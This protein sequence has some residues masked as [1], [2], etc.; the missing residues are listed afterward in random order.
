MLECVFVCAGFRTGFLVVGGKKL[1]SS[2]WR[3]WIAR[4]TT[5]AVLWAW[6]PRFFFFFF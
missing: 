4:I 6:S 1:Q 5:R 3:W 2:V